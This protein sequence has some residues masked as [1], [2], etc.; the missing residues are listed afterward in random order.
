MLDK[1]S[2]GSMVS[3][4]PEGMDDMENISTDEDGAEILPF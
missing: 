4:A 1:R 2:E 3:G